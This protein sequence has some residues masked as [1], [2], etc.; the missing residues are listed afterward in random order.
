MVQIKVFLAPPVLRRGSWVSVALIDGRR[1]LVIGQS[2]SLENC[3]KSGA[4]FSRKVESNVGDNSHIIEAIDAAAAQA[5]PKAAPKAAPPLEE[6]EEEEEEEAEE[7]DDDKEFIPHLTLAGLIDTDA[8]FREGAMRP[9]RI[10][11]PIVADSGVSLQLT[12]FL[13]LLLDEG[14]DACMYN[15]PVHNVCQSSTPLSTLEESCAHHSESSPVDHLGASAA[16]ISSEVISSEVQCHGQDAVTGFE[17]E[18]DDALIMEQGTARPIGGELWTLLKAHDAIAS[19]TCL[20]H[21]AAGLITLTAHRGREYTWDRPAATDGL[22]DE[23]AAIEA[24]ALSGVGVSSFGV[25]LA[26]GPPVNTTATRDDS[27]D[28]AIDAI[29]EAT[30]LAAAPLKCYA[31]RLVVLYCAYR[32]LKVAKASDLLIAVAVAS[33]PISR[34]VSLFDRKAAL[35]CSLRQ[36]DAACIWLQMR[37]DNHWGVLLEATIDSQGAATATILPPPPQGAALGPSVL[38]PLV[39]PGALV[40]ALT[41]RSGG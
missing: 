18:D 24:V 38:P 41:E 37:A 5:A 8:C 26:E 30:P 34:E 11:R 15:E 3:L 22:A 40:A 31:A 2:S 23:D 27:D 28:A 4:Y 25:M 21:R 29:D 12:H 19:T 17:D 33:S 1:I 10:H 9:K 32:M 7:D 36:H 20:L 14:G 16:V 39:G 35:P 13:G 6:E